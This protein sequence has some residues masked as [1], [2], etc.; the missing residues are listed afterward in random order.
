MNEPYNSSSH[1]V[2]I[3]IT[4]S[5]DGYKCT[6]NA[7]A[8]WPLGNGDNAQA[9]VGREF[10][11]YKVANTSSLEMK[12]VTDAAKRDALRELVTQLNLHGVL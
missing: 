3:N 11:S 9:C 1:N 5:D 2:T 6:I 10:D 4:V 7:F 8:T 12:Q